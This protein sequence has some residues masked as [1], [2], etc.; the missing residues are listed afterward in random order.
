M[1]DSS[2]NIRWLKNAY[3]YPFRPTGFGAWVAN[4]SRP[5]LIHGTAKAGKM[6]IG[7]AEIKVR[8]VLPWNVLGM[9]LCH[10]GNAAHTHTHTH[11]HKHTHTHTHTGDWCG[12]HRRNVL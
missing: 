2:I 11:T 4:A 5:I 7:E 3:L 10:V 8:A 1:N 6:V 12:W 9:I